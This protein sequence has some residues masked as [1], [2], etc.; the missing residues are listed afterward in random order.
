M[1]VIEQDFDPGMDNI[2]IEVPP[3][4]AKELGVNPIPVQDR[5]GRPRWINTRQ[6]FCLDSKVDSCNIVMRKECPSKHLEKQQRGPGKWLYATN[7]DFGKQPEDEMVEN[8]VPPQI[9]GPA[10]VVEEVLI[11]SAA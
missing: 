5:W 11:T 3:L 7:P 8:I 1:E 6:C 4:S 10:A 9:S 2:I